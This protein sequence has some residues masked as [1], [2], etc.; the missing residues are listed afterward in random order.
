MYKYNDWETFLC[1]IHEVY[2]LKVISD[3]LLKLPNDDDR[4]NDL[5][6]D[7]VCIWGVIWIMLQDFD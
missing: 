6:N 4:N 2:D 3:V 7:E 5:P 1:K